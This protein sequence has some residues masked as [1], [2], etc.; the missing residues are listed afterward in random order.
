LRQ[1]PSTCLSQILLCR[2]GGNDAIADSSGYLLGRTGASFA[3]G[4]RRRPLRFPSSH[5]T[6]RH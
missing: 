6:P 2:E 3:G 4:Q 1:A 5:A